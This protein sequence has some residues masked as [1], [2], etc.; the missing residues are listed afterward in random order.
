LVFEALRE[1]LELVPRWLLVLLVFIGGAIEATPVLGILVPANTF[2][3]LIG[4]QWAT[5]GWWPMDLMAAYFVGSFLGDVAYFSA[6]RHF[7]LSFMERWPGLLKLSPD[8]R[9]A[10]EKLFDA[11][12]GKT[13][14]LA[15]F[16]PVTRN[17]APY[18][19][20]AA[21]LSAARFLTVSILGSAFTAVMVVLGGYLTGLGL[22]AVVNAIGR[23]ATIA[24]G[25]FVVVVI[26]FLWW[27]NRSKKRA[28]AVEATQDS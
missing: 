4:I 5:L 1:A 21:R 8:R 20:G 10:L 23:T 14:L 27:R 2:V 9:Q 7:G 11:H 12:G 26:A 22:G 13:V 3:F 18:I 25:A 24:G 17:F 28:A 15:R 16:Q 6:G 19:A